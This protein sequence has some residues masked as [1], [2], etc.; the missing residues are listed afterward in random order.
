MMTTKTRSVSTPP[1][2]GAFTKETLIRGRPARIGCIRIAD[3]TYSISGGPIAIARLEDEW[4]EDVKDPDAVIAFLNEN[5]D[6]RPDI[7]TFWQR[8]PDLTP[9]YPFHLEWDHIAAMPTSS[10][11]DWFQHH[12]KPRVRTSIRKAEKEGV[13]VKETVWDDAFVR[14]MTALFN[15]SP[16]RQGARFWHYGKDFATVKEQFSRFLH[17]EHLIGAYY[18]D[19]MIGFIMLGNAGRFGLTG[20]ILSSITHRDKATNVALVAKAVEVCEQRQFGR[21]VY[22][23]WTEGSL[24]EFKRRCGF[25]KTA[26]PRD[27]VPLTLKGKLALSC[28]VHRGWRTLIPQPMKASLKRLRTAWTA[29]Q[30]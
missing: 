10:Y 30:E 4:Y 8:L 26:V 1:D 13:V 28:G 7:V 15:E 24:T 23:F 20:Q 25:E 18:K 12:I 3:Q 29:R 11:K 21:L 19:E 6:F 27:Y 16:F 14:G 2:S 17:R 22:L 5:P 9:K